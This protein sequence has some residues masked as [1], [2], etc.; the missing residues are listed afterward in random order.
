MCFLLC[1]S[2]CEVTLVF[3][4]CFDGD[5]FCVCQLKIKNINIVLHML[6]ICRFWENDVAFLNMPAQNNLHIGFSILFA[7]FGK[8]WFTN[9]CAV[10]MT[11]GIPT[12]NCRTIRSNT[13][14]QSI[15][16]IIWMALYLAE[17]QA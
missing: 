1:E 2:E 13:F 16:L 6:R 10:P 9:Q 4:Q 14:F 8:N 7:Q 17:R 12:L 3:I 15:L 11:D 5:H